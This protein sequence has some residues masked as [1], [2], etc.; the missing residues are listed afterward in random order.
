M[1]AK[2]DASTPLARIDGLLQRAR[3]RLPARARPGD[4]AGIVGQGGL[5]IDTRPA[6]QRARDGELPGAIVVDRNVLEWRLDP[7]CPYHI[8]EIREA[9]QTVI[10]VCDEGYSSSLAAASLQDLGLVNATDLAG[11]FQAWR[12]WSADRPPAPAG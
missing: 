11:G 4:L 8:P 3:A 12:R 7:S 9:A 10:I 6:A 2:P 1:S 5:V